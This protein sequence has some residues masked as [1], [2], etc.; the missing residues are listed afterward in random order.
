[1]G[2]E[3]GRRK[4]RSPETLEVADFRERIQFPLTFPSR[5]DMSLKRLRLNTPLLANSFSVI[6]VTAKYVAMFRLVVV[7]RAIF[8]WGASPYPEILRLPSFVRGAEINPA[9]SQCSFVA[10]G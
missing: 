4:G 7:L 3:I 5:S 8:N 9:L 10:D 2:R 1:M 6:P